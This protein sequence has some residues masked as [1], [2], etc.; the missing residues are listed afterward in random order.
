MKNDG[1]ILAIGG[2]LST[3]IGSID[4][5]FAAWSARTMLA[6]NIVVIA[7]AGVALIRRR[8]TKP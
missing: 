7:M 3:I 1:L 8:A 5:Q 2:M 6:T 4:V